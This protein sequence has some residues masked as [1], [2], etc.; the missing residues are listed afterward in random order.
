M[1]VRYHTG[2][3]ELHCAVLL[4]GMLLLQC[5]WGVTQAAEGCAVHPAQLEE[6]PGAHRLPAAP[7]QSGAPAVCL[8]QQAGPPGAA[9]E[10]VLAEG[11]WQAAAGLLCWL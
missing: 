2:S 11:S 4:D 8:A 1:L 6:V 7:P 9:Q 5:L 3:S 10:E